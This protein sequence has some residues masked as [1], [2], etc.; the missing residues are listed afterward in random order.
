MGYALDRRRN[1]ENCLIGVVVLRLLDRIEL[2]NLLEQNPI[3]RLVG[4]SYHRQSL[5]PIKEHCSASYKAPQVRLLQK[6]TLRRK[7]SAE[8]KKNNF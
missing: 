8:G 5:S 6:Q 1:S 2:G 7:N 4:I 3:G